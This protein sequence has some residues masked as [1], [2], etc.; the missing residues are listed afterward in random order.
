MFELNEGFNINMYYPVESEPY[1]P[2]Q[3]VMRV[4]WSSKSRI[5]EVAN[6]IEVK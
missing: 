4:L 2:V 3:K 6:C 5:I 1:Y